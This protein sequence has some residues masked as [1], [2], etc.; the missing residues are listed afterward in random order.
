MMN[1]FRR[2]EIALSTGRRAAAVGAAALLVMSFLVSC[3]AS[4]GYGMREETDAPIRGGLDRQ[5]RVAIADRDIQGRPA[6][7]LSDSEMGE[8]VQDSSDGGRRWVLEFKD[9]LLKYRKNYAT[10]DET[11]KH[12]STYVT[13]VQMIEAHNREDQ[14]YKLAVNEFTDMTFEEFK[15]TYLM[16][17]ANM[18]VPACSGS[19]PGSHI[20]SS[21]AVIPSKVDWRKKDIVSP[22]KNQGKCGSCWAFSATGAV[23]AA[24]AQATGVNVLL[25]EQQLLDCSRDYFNSGCNGG[26]F[27]RAFEYV[28]HKR[29]LDTE[30]SYPYTGQDEKCRFDRSNSGARVFDV[31]NITSFDEEG[32][33]DAVAFQRPVSIAFE[34]VPDFMHYSSGIYSSKD[35]TGDVMMLNHAVLAVGYVAKQGETPYWIVKNSWGKDWGE[36]GYFKVEQGINMCGVASCASYPVVTGDH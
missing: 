17:F 1:A 35:C 30:D 12:Y 9:F 3:A 28:M 25:S 13:N 32:V 33:K 18:Q 22:V 34:A 2:M 14:S 31:V 11:Q 24:W 4:S 19:D 36:E 8:L 16:D 7:S 21:E 29:G 10:M 20:M 5:M 26:Y 23:E 15:S 6:Q 27:T